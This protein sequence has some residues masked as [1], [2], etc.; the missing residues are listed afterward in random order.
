M[1]THNHISIITQTH[2]TTDNHLPV[3]KKDSH[4]VELW[5][6]RSPQRTWIFLSWHLCGDILI[7]VL[8]S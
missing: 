8:Q 3:V 4:G 7:L 1:M 5:V 6:I 2:C